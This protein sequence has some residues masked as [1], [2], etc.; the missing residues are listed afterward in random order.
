MSTDCFALLD[1][2]RRPGLDLDALKSRF[3]QLSSAL[4]PDRFHEA[5]IQERMSAGDRFTSLNSAY[6]T[7]LDPKERLRHLYALETGGPPRDIQ[8]IPPGTMDLFIEV[9]QACR[10]IDGFLG[11]PGEGLSPLVKVQRIRTARHSVTQ[12][13]ALQSNINAKRDEW[14]RV[15]ESINAAWAAMAEVSSAEE[16]RQKLPL[17][18]LLEV[19]R[20]LSYVGRWT[21]QIQQRIAELVGVG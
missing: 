9:G 8:K 5:P 21:E 18:R 15:I 11:Q 4:H 12:L 14:F 3:I 13:Q 10:D 6:Q 19:Y 2:P 17:D 16:R 1:E 7:L 20:G